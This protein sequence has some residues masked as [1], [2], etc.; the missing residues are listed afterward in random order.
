MK[1]PRLVMVVMLTLAIPWI[2]WADPLPTAVENDFK[3]LK[4]IVIGKEGDGWLIDAGRGL[5]VHEGDIFTV[6]SPGKTVVH[7]QTGEKLG[8]IQ[9]ITGLL[10][11]I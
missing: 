1:L 3:P 2:G 4:A 7:P 5:G 8:T 9:Q 11:V 6:V 10:Q